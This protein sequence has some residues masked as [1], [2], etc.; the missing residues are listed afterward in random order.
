[1]LLLAPVVRGANREVALSAL[2]ALGLALLAVLL[3][4]VFGRWS[5]RWFSG[6]PAGGYV[7]QSS[8]TQPVWWWGAVLVVSA[9]PL[10]VGL[11]QLVPVPLEWWAGLPGRDAYPAAMQ[12]AG[13]ELPGRLPIS[14]NPQATW[15]AL[16]SSVPLV[17]V[18]LVALQ[19]PRVYIDKL[20]TALLLA[21]LFQVVLSVT[22]FASGRQSPVY[23]GLVGQ[24]FI[25]SFANRNH[26]A[27][28]LAML[29]PV[30]FYGWLRIQ[31]ETDGHGF[32]SRAV[33]RPIWLMLGFAFLVV[34]LSTQSRGGI[35]ATTMVLLLSAVLMGYS[36]RQ[37]LARWQRWGLAGLFLLFVGLAVSLI[38]VQGLMNRIQSGR[39]QTDADVRQAFALATWEAARTFW[40]WGSGMGSFESVFPR[41]QQA[42]TPGYVNH[43]HN[44]YP[45]LLMEMG[46]PALLLVGLLLVLVFRQVWLLAQA[47]RASKR[48]SSEL[49]VRC[50][51]GLGALALLLHSWVEF[52]MHIPALAMTAS[53]LMGV[54]LRPLA[55]D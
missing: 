47:F 20:M 4:Q 15:S 7:Q 12:A 55:H 2:L 54:F 32:R 48:F 19:L 28:F 9:S 31:R 21:G 36:I 11:L 6:R 5:V 24:G 35:L 8:L 45:Q 25:G 14:L 30:W 16:W 3:A 33:R 40:P 1:M 22:Q 17:A 44:D 26:L 41:F 37:K 46:A 34:I 18:F 27:D 23:F 49:G 13:V 53:F 10:W 50:F 29:V 43:A 52:N 42:L 38:D 39:L 51:A